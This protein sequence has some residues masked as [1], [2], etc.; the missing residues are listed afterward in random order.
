MQVHIPIRYQVLLESAMALNYGHPSAF[1]V[2]DTFLT[3]LRIN[4]IPFTT[5]YAQPP[6][7]EAARTELTTI[8]PA[9][10]WTSIMR[11]NNDD[12]A[13]AICQEDSIQTGECILRLSCLH[14]FH[15]KCIIEWAKYKPV[16]PLCNLSIEVF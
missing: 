7:Q 14:I 4:N 9:T 6:V 13:C 3:M 11:Q 2:N 8:N 5:S 16:C 1:A 12:K 15:T 10:V